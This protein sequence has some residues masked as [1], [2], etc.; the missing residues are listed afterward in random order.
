MPV[1]QFVIG[2]STDQGQVALG[3]QN[4]F[5]VSSTIDPTNTSKVVLRGSEIVSDGLT[6]GRDI[7][8]FSGAPDCPD[9]DRQLLAGHRIFDHSCV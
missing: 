8:Y 6:I 4:K 3:D 7:A 1:Q 9:R 2:G 5:F